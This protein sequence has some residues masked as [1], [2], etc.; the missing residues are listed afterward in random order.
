[1]RLHDARSEN[2][3]QK[4]PRRIMRDVSGR[5]AEDGAL[6][7]RGSARTGPR[8]PAGT[9]PGVLPGCLPRGPGPRSV[10]ARPD[11][12][13][14]PRALWVSETLVTLTSC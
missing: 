6:E 3:D 5:G 4:S 1:M 12:T 8:G 10:E 9:T 7:S 14:P 2:N 13:F 11:S